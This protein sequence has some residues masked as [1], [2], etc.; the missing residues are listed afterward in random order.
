MM[1]EFLLK[2]AICWD[3]TFF[4]EAGKKQRTPWEW[5]RRSY[6]TDSR[7]SQTVQPADLLT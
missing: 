6:K 4:K 3:N 5:L 7:L 1:A 2:Q